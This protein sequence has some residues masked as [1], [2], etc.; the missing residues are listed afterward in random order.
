[1]RDKLTWNEL[2][3]A[4]PSCSNREAR[5]TSSRVEDSGSVEHCCVRR[6]QSVLDLYSTWS[7][8]RIC[9]QRSGVISH[10]LTHS[11]FDEAYLTFLRRTASLK[12]SPREITRRPSAE[13][14]KSKIRSES[15]AV[16]FL[17]VLPFNCT[18]QIFPTVYPA[19]FTPICG[20][21]TL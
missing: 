10:T 5:S 8:S 16:S 13:T 2:W 12:M 7:N 21:A 15:K 20:N 11:V 3:R 19:K 6:D 4:P 9:C 17:G 14:S 1:M 18:D